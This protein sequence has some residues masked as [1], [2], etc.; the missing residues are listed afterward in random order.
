MPAR[1][2]L[3]YRW[4]PITGSRQPSVF[5]MSSAL[6]SRNRMDLSGVAVWVDRAESRDLRAGRG[7]VEDASP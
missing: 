7:L 2:R 5:Q 6:N 4:L 3:F 1:I